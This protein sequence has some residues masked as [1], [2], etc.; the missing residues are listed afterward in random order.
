M[1][2]CGIG[3]SKLFGVGVVLYIPCF[4]PSLVG[5]GAGLTTGS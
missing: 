2:D 1:A 5:P 4:F 3:K